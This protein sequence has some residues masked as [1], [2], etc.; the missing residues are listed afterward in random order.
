M[1]RIL[2]ETELSNI[3]S[4]DLGDILLRPIVLEDYLDMYEYGSDTDVTKYLLWSTYTKL[5]DAL[6]SVKEFFLNRPSKGI[7]QAHAII[8]K[9]TNKMIGTCDFAGYHPEESRGEIGYVLSKDYWGKGIMTKACK[10]VIEF[11]FNYLDLDL[12]TIRHHH[13]N[14]GSGV[15]AKRCGFK[16]IKDVYNKRFDTYIPYYELHRSDYENNIS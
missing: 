4:Y 1:S 5:D 10:K 2:S 14:V 8:D 9:K 3:P 12:I 13:N 11:G 7:P 6:S 15:V 16:Y